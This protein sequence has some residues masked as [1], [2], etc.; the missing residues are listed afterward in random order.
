[1]SC[2]RLEQKE[3]VNRIEGNM[4]GARKIRCIEEFRLKPSHL[5]AFMQT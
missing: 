3:Q 4:E 5:F 1:M 2:R